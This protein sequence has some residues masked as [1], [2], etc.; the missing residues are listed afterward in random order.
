MFL[1]NSFIPTI[2]DLHSEFEFI[3]NSTYD[4]VRGIWYVDSG[5][6]GPVLGITMHTHGNEPSGIAVL[7]YFRNHFKL[8]DKLQSGSIFFV[9]NNLKATED[10]FSTFEME[11]GEEKEEKK[12]RARFCDHNMNRLPENIFNLIDDERYEI[13]RAQELKKIWSKFD[14]AFD[15][16]STSKETD[17]MIIACGGLQKDL[18]SGFPVKIIITN[19]EKVQIGKPAIY[20]YGEGRAKKTRTL[21]IEAGSHENSSSFNCAIDCTTALFQNLGLIERS[22]NASRET[23]YDEYL[24]DG[25]VIFPDS[26][27]E[28]SKIF[29]MFEPIVKGQILAQNKDVKIVAQ[30]NGHVLMGSPKIN[31]TSIKEEAMFL[32]RPVRKFT[33]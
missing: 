12:R 6:K 30:F 16:H 14:V 3:K 24:V 33:I 5:K 1:N 17:P 2:N 31:P 22:M 4:N 26:S 15:I 32:S 9:I 18:I 19:I 25:S 29:E 11:D 28:M 10:Y 13:R 21:A 20:F 8:A 23:G 27:F 7:W